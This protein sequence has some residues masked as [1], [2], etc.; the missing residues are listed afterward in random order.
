MVDEIPQECERFGSDPDAWDRD[1]VVGP[2]RAGW[3][4]GAEALQRPGERAF[5]GHGEELVAGEGGAHEFVDP[6]AREV[7]QQHLAACAGALGLV[8]GGSVEEV[9]VEVAFE[10]LELGHE[11]A[12]FG[13]EVAR[14]R[15]QRR[16]GHRD[17][18]AVQSVP[19]VQCAYDRSADV[20]G[21]GGVERIQHHGAAVNALRTQGD[22]E[23]SEPAANRL[24]LDADLPGDAAG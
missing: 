22:V 15:F 16:K 13:L 2:E 7:T 9:G 14:R 21:Q 8:E 20:V 1:V 10:S 24:V 11:G 23:L 3:P 4:T 17:V 6:F 5:V 18:E 19:A 12:A